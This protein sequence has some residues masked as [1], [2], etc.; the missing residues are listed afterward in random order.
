MHG[1]ILCLHFPHLRVMLSN[2]Q[3]TAWKIRC[4]LVLLHDDN[5]DEGDDVLCH[6]R[7]LLF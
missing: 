6:Y 1:L 3:K 7:I 2:E 4:L 5:E